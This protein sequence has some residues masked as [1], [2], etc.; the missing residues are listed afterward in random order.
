MTLPGSGRRGVTAKSP[1]AYSL[2]PSLTQTALALGR[3]DERLHNHPLLPAVLFRERLEASR[4]CAAVDGHLI[5]PWRLA[6]ELEGLRPVRL[7]N[8]AYERGTSVDAARAAFDQYQWMARPTSI[9]RAEIDAALSWIADASAVDG[10]LLGAAKAFHRWIED[11]RGRSPMR[12]ALVQHWGR[13]NVLH[14][15][16]P[17]VG[18]R[19]F[20]PDA[21]W[22]PDQWLPMFLSCLA[23]EATAV[24]GRMSALERQWRLA[25]S[26]SGAR[27]KNSRADRVIDL[28]AACPMAS[29]TR[30]SEEIGMSLKAAHIY[31]GQFLA[32]GLIV[33]VTHREARRLFALKGLEPLRHVVQPPRRPLPGRSRG[34]PGRRSAGEDVETAESCE[35]VPGDPTFRLPPIDY[36][37]LEKAIAHA[38]AIM[39]ATIGRT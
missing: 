39:R 5:D 3:L 30:I 20:A 26:R 37:D 24:S 18:A 14:S 23:E 32:E 16:L 29:A 4:A 27:R 6:A 31:L 21:P 36:E 17:L 13:A 33:E 19:A 9:Q 1:G 28:L 15:P 10:P 25:R 2:A 8:D 34:R 38:E 11:G 12:G 35:L 22:K 7:G